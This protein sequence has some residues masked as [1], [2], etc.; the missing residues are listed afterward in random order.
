MN[1]VYDAQMEK[2]FALLPKEIKKFFLSLIPFLAA[3]II[4]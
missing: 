2:E 4:L 3:D 1:V